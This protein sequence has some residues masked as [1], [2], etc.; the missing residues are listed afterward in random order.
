[1]FLI[2]TIFLIAATFVAMTSWAQEDENER[3]VHSTL[4]C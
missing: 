3:I 4:Q 2:R 1:M